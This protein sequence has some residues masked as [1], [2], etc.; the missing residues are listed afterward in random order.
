MARQNA[1]SI[2]S[3]AG[4][5]ASFWIALD[6]EVRRLGGTDE[7]IYR[8]GRP[9]GEGLVKKIARLIVPVPETKPEPKKA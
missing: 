9:E 7:D 6:K 8:L 4:F 2:V 3:G 5:A 1:S